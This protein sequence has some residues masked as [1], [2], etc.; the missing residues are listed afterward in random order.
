MVSATE[1]TCLMSKQ[2]LPRGIHLLKTFFLSP[3]VKPLN[4]KLT[5]S[6]TL[7]HKE[8]DCLVV[9]FPSFGQA[10][11]TWPDPQSLRQTQNTY[12]YGSSHMV[13]A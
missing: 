9:V 6:S 11:S 12:N 1:Y 2:Q 3:F 5:F 13:F 10:L 8:V 4:E 7:L